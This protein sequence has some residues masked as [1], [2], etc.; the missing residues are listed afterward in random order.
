MKPH[1]P[2]LGYNNNI[3]YKG[4]MYHIQTEDQ[5]AGRWQIATHLFADGGRVVTSAKTSY[6]EHAGTED[7]EERVRQLMRDQHKAMVV[8]LRDGAYDHLIEAKPAVIP[9]PSQPQMAAARPPQPPAAIPRPAPPPAPSAIPDTA[10]AGRAGRAPADRPGAPAAGPLSQGR[11]AAAPAPAPRE[12]MPTAPDGSPPG[13]NM[14]S[15]LPIGTSVPI[16]VLEAAAA[17]ADNAFYR[18]IQGIDAAEPPPTPPLVPTPAGPALTPQGVK[19]P[20]PYQGGGGA[21]AVVAKRAT[22]QGEQSVGSY[23]YVSR[24]PRSGSPSGSEPPGDARV[25]FGATVLTDRSLDAVMLDFLAKL[26]DGARAR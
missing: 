21:Y 1:T 23:R 8:S 16:E 11:P 9:R 2:V 5:G 10:P 13:G 18:E 12:P 24:I 15:T 4:K 26:G 25:S 20:T 3:P 17:D 7:L 19:R 6:A 14:S 22:P